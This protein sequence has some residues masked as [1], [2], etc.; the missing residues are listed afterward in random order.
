MQTNYS[1]SWEDFK[2]TKE[3]FEVD[4]ILSN[5]EISMPY[6]QNIIQN[7]FQAGWNASGVEIEII[8]SEN[9]N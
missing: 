8:K 3:Y 2:E 6:R 7:I 9:I 5:A 1:K 4:R